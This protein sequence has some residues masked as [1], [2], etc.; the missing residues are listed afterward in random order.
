MHLPLTSDQLDIAFH[1]SRTFDEPAIV[2]RSAD[3]PQRIERLRALG[4]AVDHPLPRGVAGGANAL[5][6]SPEG[7]PLL[8]L[9]DSS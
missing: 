4:V 7:T 6:L 9:A 5:L 3:M 8:L 1:R 2:F